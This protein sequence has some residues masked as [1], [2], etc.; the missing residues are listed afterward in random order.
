MEYCPIV[1]NTLLR[2]T[3]YLSKNKY[4]SDELTVVKGSSSSNYP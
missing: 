4:M 2:Y 3:A 1:G